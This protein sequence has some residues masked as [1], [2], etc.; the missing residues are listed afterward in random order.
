MEDFEHKYSVNNTAL[1]NTLG[2]QG[3]ISVVQ[4]WHVQTLQ[5]HSHDVVI[6]MRLPPARLWQ[7]S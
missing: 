4:P 6:F 3:I 7:Q 1:G 5:A 2:R